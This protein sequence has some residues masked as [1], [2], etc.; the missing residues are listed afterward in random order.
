MRA[1]SLEGVVCCFCWTSDNFLGFSLLRR[2]K[3]HSQRRY[4][5]LAGI[6][7]IDPCLL[8]LEESPNN[9]LGLLFLSMQSTSLAYDEGSIELNDGLM[10]SMC[11]EHM[12]SCLIW[13]QEAVVHCYSSFERLELVVWL[14]VQGN[15]WKM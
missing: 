15:I 9:R 3:F 5:V 4:P 1:H 13:L 6:Y 8:D 11:V 14:L 7:C 10:G 12:A 2:Q